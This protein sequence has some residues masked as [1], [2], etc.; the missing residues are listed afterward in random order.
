MIALAS[1]SSRSPRE[2]AAPAELLVVALRV[3]GSHLWAVAAVR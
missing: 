2:L 3:Q 1:R